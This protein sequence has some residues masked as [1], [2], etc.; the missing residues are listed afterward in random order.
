MQ[1]YNVFKWLTVDLIYNEKII[2]ICQNK[3][4][5]N[6][7]NNVEHF[8]LYWNVETFW[9]YWK[10]NVN[11]ACPVMQNPAFFQQNTPPA[12]NFFKSQCVQERTF[13]LADE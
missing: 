10:K 11:S 4:K 3:K 12:R 13:F 8:V 5:N 1:G 9:L 7:L 2:A 6:N